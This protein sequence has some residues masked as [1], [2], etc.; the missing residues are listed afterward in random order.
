MPND[1]LLAK[2]VRIDY[3]SLSSPLSK[4]L[5]AVIELHNQANTGEC[6]DF[7]CCGGYTADICGFCHEEYP[8]ETIQA[9]EKELL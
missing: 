7:E 1:E 3:Y 6:G 8:C 2:I 5:R 4:A 9:I